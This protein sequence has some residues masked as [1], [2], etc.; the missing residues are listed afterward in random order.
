MLLY[1][2]YFLLPLT[3]LGL[4]YSPYSLPL[5][6]L[7]TLTLVYD[8]IFSWQFKSGEKDWHYPNTV[9]MTL[10]RKKDLISLFKSLEHKSQFFK[11]EMEN[12][13]GTRQS[14]KPYRTFFMKD[15][16]YSIYS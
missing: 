3:L 5:H 13:V 11:R 15:Q 9:D 12:I 10:Y 14:D 8:T 2:K 6:V 16:K 4:L 7:C 1:P